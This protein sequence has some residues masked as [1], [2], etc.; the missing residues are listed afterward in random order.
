MEDNR[1]GLELNDINELFVYADDVTLLGDS[2]EV[3][4]SNT[5]ILLIALGFSV[6]E[7]EGSRHQ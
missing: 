7:L 6:A 3:L 4:T 2:E 5:Y 1:K